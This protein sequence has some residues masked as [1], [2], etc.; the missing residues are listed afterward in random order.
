MIKKLEKIKNISIYGIAH[1]IVDFCCASV[2]YS[3][4]FD[5]KLFQIVEL[6]ILYKT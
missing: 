6:V 3:F 4:V 5:L 2:L 1:A